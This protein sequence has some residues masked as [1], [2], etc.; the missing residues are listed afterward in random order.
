MKQDPESDITK[1]VITSSFILDNTQNFFPDSIILDR[2]FNILGVS[3][4]ILFRLGFEQQEL[5]GHPIGVLQPGIRLADWLTEKL[6]SGYFIE[7]KLA[8]SK[9]VGGMVDYVVSGFYLAILNV[10]SDVIVLRFE[11]RGEIE[12]LSDK[13]Q[14]AWA[15]IDAFIYRTAHDIRG[16]LATIQGLLNLLKTRKD[17]SEVDLFVSMIDT[18]C[19]KLDDRIKNIIYLVNSDEEF[20]SPSFELHISE[21]ETSL[22]KTIERN[23]FVDSLLLTVEGSQ[24]V[25]F[26]YNE[27]LVK[28]AINNLLMFL[29]SLRKVKDD[30]QIDIKIYANEGSVTICILC[31]GFE[32]DPRVSQVLRDPD[33]SHYVDVLQ[34]PGLT[35]LFAVQKIAVKL[36]AFTQFAMLDADRQQFSMM[37]RR[38]TITNHAG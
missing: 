34:S 21:L 35:Y 6:S 20:F 2:K 32:I 37:I 23:V 18:H 28:L 14:N 31:W 16:P 1:T 30:R 10:F 9:K 7:E 17:N 3:S 26:G 33:G 4:S 8:F 19:L 11:Y 5:I 25:F 27:E 24:D 12:E 38:Q 36:K 29:L 15:Q 13:L 22:R